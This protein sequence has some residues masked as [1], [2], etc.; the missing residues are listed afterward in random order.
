MCCVFGVWNYSM[1]MSR[2]S[3]R[4]Y[5]FPSGVLRTVYHACIVRT[6]FGRLCNCRYV[7]RIPCLSSFEKDYMTKYV[8]RNKQTPLATKNLLEVTDGLGRPP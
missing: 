4:L 1:L 3:S 6:H 2:L 7:D 8:G 5:T